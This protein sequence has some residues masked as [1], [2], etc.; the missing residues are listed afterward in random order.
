M[1]E[2]RLDIKDFQPYSS[3]SDNDKVLMA[4]GGTG[5]DASIT[6]ALLRT[7]LTNG[8]KPEIKD[9]VWY[10][11][12][13]STGVS[14]GAVQLR[15][16]ENG[17]EYRYSDNDE[18]A[19]LITVSKLQ[20]PAVNIA[21]EL[22]THPCKVSENYTWMIWDAVNKV[23][24][25]TGISARGR[26]PLIRDMIWWVW[27]EEK[28]DYVSTG[29]AVNDTFVLTKEDVEGVFVGNVVG[30]HHLEYTVPTID[31]VPTDTTL[32]WTDSDNNLY[33]FYVGQLCRVA[34]SSFDNGYKFYQLYDIKDG[35]AVW[36]EISGGGGVGKTYPD[37]VN[38]EIFNDYENNIAFGKCA[39][40]EG[41]ETNATGPRAHAEGYQTKVFAADAHAE[42]RETWCLGS[43]GHAEGFYSMVYGNN[44]HV[45][46]CAYDT[47]S[48]SPATR[49]MLA[50]EDEEIIRNLYATEFIPFDKVLNVPDSFF[51]KYIIH[52]SFGE[53]SH[54]EGTNNI[55]L[56]N[57]S[58]VEG[59]CNRC[60]NMITGHSHAKIHNAN[61]I[62]GQYNYIGGTLEYTYS[63][64]VEG[65]NNEFRGK[66][67]YP[68]HAVHIEGHYNTIPLLTDGVS[69][70]NG[71]HLGGEYSKILGGRSTFAH[72]YNLS[73][74][75]NYE[76][77]FGKFNASEVEG[78]S[79]LF[80]YG[81]GTSDSNRK[82]AISIF[83]DGSVEIPKLIS[84]TEGLDEKV[85]QLEKII[86]DNYDTLSS[87]ITGILNLLSTDNIDKKA[88]VVADSLIITYKVDANV[89]GAT[90]TI[91]DVDFS[92]EDNNLIYESKVRAY[93]TEDN[94]YITE[95]I[96]AKVDA[97]ELIIQD[98]KIN[99]VNNNLNI[100]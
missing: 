70:C 60:G 61:H 99:V 82:N 4:K 51:E 58:H 18:W 17:I 52:A 20:E 1:E 76:A 25:D 59:F 45:E 80:S 12:G 62:E 86:S 34:D 15:L 87:K 50:T 28:G 44:S 71:A 26:S 95:S 36:G 41:Q 29:Q 68:T 91:N 63:I 88:F 54:V 22:R 7:I 89:E 79:V 11:G 21:E 73:V 46:G 85:E 84:S 67:D 53:R 42:G 57:S 66:Y 30:H 100:I 33:M 78:K 69:S 6:I 10:I 19:M 48:S 98:E 32:T 93:V 92:V 23:Y 56:D 94:L 90:L 81:I 49:I 35:A 24:T 43:Q 2:K 38:G 37:T 9:G 14:A 97:S 65:N 27:D 55:C 75:N 39:H 40:A 5:T 47:D 77:A 13:V 31:S 72:G 74:K 16:G 3:V 83:S 96:D 8:I 64:H